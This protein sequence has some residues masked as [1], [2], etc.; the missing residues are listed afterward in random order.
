MPGASERFDIDTSVAQD[1][2]ALR[3]RSVS[4]SELEWRAH[5][6]AAHLVDLVDSGFSLGFLAP[7]THDDARRYW[8]SLGAELQAGLRVLLVASVGDRIVGSG[9]LEFPPWANARHRATVNKVFTIADARGCG[10]GT[11]LMH[12]LHYAARQRG[13]SLMLL[14]TRC[15]GYAEG[16]Y[17]K[18]GYARIG[19]TPGYYKDASGTRSDNVSLYNELSARS[20]SKA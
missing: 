16:F 1:D 17:K 8:L 3:I 15:G 7:L 14:H 5:E 12:A 10:F 20:A 19:V 9:Q 13:R 18:L 6:L 11:A 4:A 2:D